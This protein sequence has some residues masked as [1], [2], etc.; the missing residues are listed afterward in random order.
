MGTDRNASAFQAN[1]ELAFIGTGP[2]ENQFHDDLH[3]WK[4]LEWGFSF[5]FF[6]YPVGFA[7]YGVRR[8]RTHTHTHT[9]RHIH[10]RVRFIGAADGK[11]RR[12]S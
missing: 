11:P 9:H 12:N 3:G 7:W 2:Y 8:R 6:F 5:A 4:R 1:Q 10:T